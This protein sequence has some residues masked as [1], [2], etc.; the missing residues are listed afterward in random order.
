VDNY[1]G[2]WSQLQDDPL[3]VN[4]NPGSWSQIPDD[5]LPVELVTGIRIADKNW[6]IAGGIV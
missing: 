6:S 3:P 4:N 1:L 2:S 5:Q